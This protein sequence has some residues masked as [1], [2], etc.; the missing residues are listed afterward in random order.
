MAQ[1]VPNTPSCHEFFLCW[2]P[3][4]QVE[5][6]TMLTD[7]SRINLH[8]DSQTIYTNGWLS[9]S[10]C[11]DSITDQT[12]ENQKGLPTMWGGM[13]R[14][15]C[16]PHPGLCCRWWQPQASVQGK[17]RSYLILGEQ[18]IVAC[19][20]VWKTAI[21]MQPLRMLLG[22]LGII[23]N[24]SRDYYYWSIYGTSI[25]LPSNM[26]MESLHVEI[27]FHITNKTRTIVLLLAN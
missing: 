24:R 27:V 11:S 10:T 4:L 5:F 3:C 26:L 21:G 19:L 25:G 23:I 6:L 22:G 7:G 18:F 17:M 8:G 2:I 20:I 15:D 13:A 16:W 12:K 14:R 9:F 1:L